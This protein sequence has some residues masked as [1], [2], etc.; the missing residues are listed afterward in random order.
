MKFI[1]Y[2]S[3]L[4]I[5]IFS[6]CTLIQVAQDSKEAYKTSTTHGY[7]NGIKPAEIRNIKDYIADENDFVILAESSHKTVYMSRTTSNSGKFAMHSASAD[8]CEE[9]GGKVEFGKQAGIS[10]SVDFDSIAFEFS[11]VKS[12][13]KKA[14]VREYDGWM[15][16]VNSND[17]FEIRRKNRTKYF[18]IT[19][20][21]EQP[22]G[23]SFQ[24]YIDYFNIE[25]IDPDTV[26]TGGF[27]HI[28]L[29]YL[30]SLCICNNGD[31]FISNKYTQNIDMNM[32][33]YIINQLS[34]LSGEK[35]YLLA[36]GSLSCKNSDLNNSDF[37]YDISYSKQY[38]SLI[39]NKRQ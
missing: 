16:C 1:L 25:N 4:F 15:R 10:I 2:S 7:Q 37:I 23:Y 6:G 36:Q 22:Q 18:T 20:E 27:K 9:I 29:V 28:N 13:Y 3:S 30:S 21:K 19:H 38:Q 34:P 31:V 14:R 5:F 33:D 35:G 12:N 8:Y 11:S 39:Y 32:N 24:W 26:Q 17:D